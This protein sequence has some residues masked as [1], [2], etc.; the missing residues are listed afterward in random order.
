MNVK[1]DSPMICIQRFYIVAINLAT[2][3]LNPKF[4]TFVDSSKKRQT[5]SFVLA[6]FSKGGSYDVHV[7]KFKYWHNLS[8]KFSKFMGVNDKWGSRHYFHER[9]WYCNH[10]GVSGITTSYS[11]LGGWNSHITS[12]LRCGRPVCS[13]PTGLGV[14]GSK[15]GFAVDF[16]I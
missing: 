2:Q 8:N 9:V 15:V 14:M 13:G 1:L 10:F 16:Y 3:C 12:Q 6:V 11:N 5:S 7:T 4:N